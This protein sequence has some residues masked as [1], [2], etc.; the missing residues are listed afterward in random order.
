MRVLA[1]TVAFIATLVG[2][3][4]LMA[5]KRDCRPTRLPEQLPAA[6]A[7]IDSARAIADLASFSRSDRVM[8]FSLVFH[9]DDSLPGV[10]PMD[11]ADAIAAVLLMRSLRPQPPSETWAIRVRVVEGR[12]PMLALE[13][14]VYCPPVP[15]WLRPMEITN[16]TA[17]DLQNAARAP[18]ENLHIDGF[19]A[20]V[21]TEGR[22][23]VV[24]II[25]STGV[26]A[27]D[28]EVVRDLKL[29]QFQPALLDGQPIQAVYRTDGKSPRP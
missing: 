28:E 8:L 1:V 4:P 2:S 5:Q 22:A 19:E 21:S 15:D 11:K 27:A 10:R 24:R 7:L 16:V 20:L 29:R 6:S 3:S 13:R 26:R 12:D 23:L 14:S 17:I 9:E 18:K 25:G